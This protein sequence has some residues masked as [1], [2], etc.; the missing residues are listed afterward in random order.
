MR[1]VYW[2][3]FPVSNRS[4]RLEQMSQFSDQSATPFSDH[5][6]KATGYDLADVDVV[7]FSPIQ[8]TRS[9]IRDAVHG[10]GIRRV[11]VIVSVEKLRHAVRETEFDML[12]LEAKEHLEAV[13]EHIREFRHG[14]LSNNPFLVINVITW[15]PSDDVIRTFIDAGADDIIVMPISIGAVTSRVDNIIEKRKKFIATS[16]YV[17][18]ERRSQSRADEGELGG[19][20]VP[21]GVRF[22]ATGDVSA[23]V[24]ME[25]IERANRIVMEHRLRRT[26]LRFVE[27]AAMLE[28]FKTEN[29]GQSVAR[30]EL[31]GMTE[32]VRYIAQQTGNDARSE[33]PE[34]VSSL[35]NV[36]NEVAQESRPEA[37]LFALLRIHGEA[38]L[39][40]LRGEDEAAELVVRSVF[41]ATKIIEK[42]TAKKK[43]SATDHVADRASS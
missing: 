39:A 43:N 2:S 29:P 11:N 35:Q 40:L 36:M 26:T 8:N 17:G 14:R 1:A 24:D 4:Q 3:Y 16:R 37:D 32:L 33:I 27:I 19:F 34:L 23:Q 22:K 6:R 9:V 41:T 38:L 13:C 25:K 20:V 42:R 21:N 28:H 30:K 15:L 5:S 18:P 31:A 7:L 12:V 10:A